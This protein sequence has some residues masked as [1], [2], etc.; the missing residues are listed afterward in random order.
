MRS[1][2]HRRSKKK[3]KKQ[4]RFSICSFFLLLLQDKAIRLWILCSDQQ[5]HPKK[6][7][8][9]WNSILDGSRGHL[10]NPIWHRG[11]E[12]VLTKKYFNYLF[13][14]FFKENIY[15][16]KYVFT[17]FWSSCHVISNISVS[18]YY[19]TRVWKLYFDTDS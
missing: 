1:V 15:S 3:Q 17:F 10:Q 11:K 4:A 7:V 13:I 12:I 5:R 18:G 19:C 16:R 14:I 6:E 2:I 8:T 9:S